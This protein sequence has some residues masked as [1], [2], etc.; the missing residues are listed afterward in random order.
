MEENVR[1][2]AGFA[3]FSGLLAALALTLSL[4]E[5]MLPPLPGMPPGAKLGLSNVVMM[6]AAGTLGLPLALAL[7]VIKGGFALLTRGVTAGAMSL[8]GGL[9]STICAWALLKNTRASLSL[10]GICGALAHNLGQLL[11]ALWLLGP[12]VLAYG[13]VLALASIL[14][15]ALTGA[16]FKVSLPPLQRA[17]GYLLGKNK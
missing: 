11:I 17:S 7:A 5:G 15:G 9:L 13:P 8:S 1:K 2:K 10:T 6:Y 3:A 4:L 14:T 12:A 16:L